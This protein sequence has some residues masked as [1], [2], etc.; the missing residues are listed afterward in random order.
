[1]LSPRWSN[2]Q[3][4]GSE[5]WMLLIHHTQTKKGLTDRGLVSE[6]GVELGPLGP[7]PDGLPLPQPLLQCRPAPALI[8]YKFHTLEQSLENVWRFPNPPPQ[9][10]IDPARLHHRG[11]IIG[12]TSSGL[13]HRGYIIGVTSLVIGII[14]RN[15]NQPTYLQYQGKL[16]RTSAIIR[17]RQDFTN[18]RSARYGNQ[19]SAGVCGS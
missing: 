4:L 11:Y 12:V 10:S 9:S 3:P 6:L 1:M 7:R 17:I 18:L 13:H 14:G 2:Q 19:D 15:F 5:P 16:T 8:I